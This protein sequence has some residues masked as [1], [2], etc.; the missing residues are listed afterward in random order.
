MKLLLNDEFYSYHGSRITTD[1]AVDFICR[2]TSN[3]VQTNDLSDMN[4][5][6]G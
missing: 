2:Q 1:G 3:H 5:G 4:Q 6:R